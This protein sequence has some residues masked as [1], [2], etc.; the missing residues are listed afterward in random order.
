MSSEPMT[1]EELEQ[2]RATLDAWESSPIQPRGTL[3]GDMRRLVEHID[4]LTAENAALRERLAV[5]EKEY[6]RQ[7]ELHAAMQSDYGD[8]K[9][10]VYINCA[11]DLAALATAERA[12]K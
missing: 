2:I 3:Y 12:T 7:A 11:D 4:T 6:R 9:A 5:L 8:G 1:A 10:R